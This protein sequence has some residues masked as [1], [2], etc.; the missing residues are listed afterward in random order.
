MRTVV[1]LRAQAVVLGVSSEMIAPPVSTRQGEVVA[2][3]RYTSRER[4]VPC[5]I[6]RIGTVMP[7]TSRA[8]AQRLATQQKSRRRRAP[9]QA[10]QTPVTVERILDEVAP[11]D[12]GAVQAEEMSAPVIESGRPAS[13]LAQSASRRTAGPTA[14]TV[15]TRRRYADYAV[16]YAHV[17]G[18][19]RRIAVV[20]GALLALLIVLSFFIA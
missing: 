2:E 3:L 12:T 17:W 11:L 16:E 10:P 15:P 9:K 7:R 5:S 4:G 6:F 14:R 20:A 8:V 18:D 13:R 1:L 19:L